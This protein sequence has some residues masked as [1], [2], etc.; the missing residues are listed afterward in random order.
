MNM[1]IGG[2]RT[3]RQAIAGTDSK[4]KVLD[5]IIIPGVPPEFELPPIS[6]GGNDYGFI[7]ERRDAFVAAGKPY[8]LPVSIVMPVYNRK[9]I[10][11]KTIA[12]LCR[13]NYPLE[14]MELVVA[15]DG[16]S[17]GVEEVIEKYR[18]FL[19]IRH[20]FQEDRGYRLAE[21]RNLGI[22]TASHDHLILLDCDMLPVP[23][24]VASFM[25]FLHVTEQAILIGHR[26]F[27]RTDHL[28]DDDILTDITL[29]THLP[30]VVPENPSFDDDS[31]KNPIHDGAARKAGQPDVPRTGD[32]R[33]PLYGKTDYLK[34]SIAPFVV[35]SG[36][37]LAFPRSLAERAGPFCEEFRAWG[38]E[39][40]EW[41]YR[42]FDAGFYFIPVP[43]TVGLHQEPP[44][45]RNEIDRVAGRAVTQP[46]MEDRC[47]LV[48]RDYV[49]HRVNSVPK[50][51]VYMPAYNCAR[52]I[53]QAVDSVLAQD[54]TD[55]EVCIVDDGST[56]DTLERLERRYKNNPRVR[57]STQERGGIGKASNAAARMCRAPYIGQLDADDML[58]SHA[59]RTMV[60]YLDTHNV[61]CVYGN[62]EYI[63]ADGR[64][65]RPGREWPVFSRE[66]LSL[67]MIVHHFRAFRKRDWNRTSGF[68][69]HLENSVDYEMFIRLSEVCAIAHIPRDVMYLYRWHGLNTS[70]AR[71]D[72]QCRNHVRV[73]RR[74]LQRTGLDRTWELHVPE[75][76][77]LE[78]LEYYRRRPLDL[79]KVES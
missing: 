28:S 58:K 11:A 2:K 29:A 25:A 15:D 67:S 24:L 32:W 41:A 51:S 64:F 6:G 33:L 75:P 16:S 49:P 63:D 39:D 21:V 61:G 56:D 42:V 34:R 59:V 47:P 22:R 30:D 18:R 50:F 79:D 45:G 7:E 65:L 31:S 57:W 1:A 13:Q 26:R 53:A 55:L 38:A 52:Y 72:Q 19:P 70:I 69:E 62:Y 14:L 71:Y 68:D 36:G 76:L 8:T 77:D 66:M 27:V 37:N 12:A 4:W 60:D 17:D 23:E 48:F 73:I 43:R 9:D 20:A 35:C 54:F 46:L 3:A 78:A 10:L 44:G 74:A 40:T 5:G